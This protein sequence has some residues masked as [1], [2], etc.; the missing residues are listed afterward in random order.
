MPRQNR[1][2]ACWQALVRVDHQHP[3][4]PRRDRAG[5]RQVVV[6]AE[7]GRHH[8]QPGAGLSADEFDLVLAQHRNERVLDHAKADEGHEQHHGV[9][10]AREL[11]GRHVTRPDAQLVQP[12]RD[13]LGLIAELTE[14]QDPIIFVDDEHPVRSQLGPGARQLPD[15][16]RDDRPDYLRG[17][18]HIHIH[19][20]HCP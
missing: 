15:A 18:C 4:L 13:G 20:W 3:R 8:Q 9:D 1:G 12:G 19:A 6:P 10:P 11:P 2:V 7:H 16:V 17:A 14:R 5:H